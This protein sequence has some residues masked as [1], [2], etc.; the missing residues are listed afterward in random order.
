MNQP[1]NIIALAEG[2]VTATVYDYVNTNQ[3]GFAV[4]Q[5]GLSLGLSPT[6]G[7]A[8]SQAGVTPSAPLCSSVGVTYDRAAGTVTFV[9]S[10]MYALVGTCAA[11]CVVNGVLAFAPQ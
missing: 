10:P 11:S 8:T 6:N 3:I 7:C 5:A 2:G 4:T 9:N 1:G